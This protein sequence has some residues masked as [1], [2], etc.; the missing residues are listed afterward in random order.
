MAVFRP[1]RAARIR[2]I[3]H[4]APTGMRGGATAR[5][6]RCRSAGSHAIVLPS[7]GPAPAPAGA[8]IAAAAVI[9][10]PVR[11]VVRRP[12]FG[13]GVDPDRFEHDIEVARHP[14]P[15]RRVAASS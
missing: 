15:R 1:S 9:V 3:P 5:R 7:R 13:D 6:A 8:A 4:D 10:I 14:E 12:I 2:L 11:I